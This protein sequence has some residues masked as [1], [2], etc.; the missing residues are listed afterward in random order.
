M[1]GRRSLALRRRDNSFKGHGSLGRRCA[2]GS[3]GNCYRRSSPSIPGSPVALRALSE[4]AFCFSLAVFF[5]CRHCKSNS[6]D[7]RMQTRLAPA[8]IRSLFP[9]ALIA[10]VLLSGPVLKAQTPAAAADIEQKIESQYGLTKTTADHSDIVTAGAVLALQKDGL[11]MSA[12]TMGSPSQNA[13]KDGKISQGL[14]K[15]TKWPGVGTI[16][17]HSGDQ[18]DHPDAELRHRREGLPHEGYGEPGQRRPRSVQRSHRE[19]AVL[20]DTQVSLSQGEIPSRRAA[21]FH[22]RRSAESAAR[23]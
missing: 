5:Y 21:C 1:S 11:L 17:S 23:R 4:S 14:W 18:S 6:G 9:G 7:D 2:F 10:I 22:H 8:L 19:R 15:A 13:Y 16:M 20:L 3:S 12:T